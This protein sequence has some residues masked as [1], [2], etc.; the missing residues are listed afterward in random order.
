MPVTLIRHGH[1][2][3]NGPPKVF[4]GRLDAAL[5]IRGVEE[6][7]ARGRDLPRPD[8]I[9]SSP[10]LRCRQTLF[11]LLPDTPPEAVRYDERLWEIDVGAWQGRLETEVEATDGERLARWRSR[12]DEQPPGGGESLQAMA[13]RVRAVVDDLLEEAAAGAHVLAVTHGGVIRQ[14]R[15]RV[16]NR[17]LREFHTFDVSNLTTYQLGRQI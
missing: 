3:C 12:P 16:E 11:A 6:A 5:S 7:R 10:A 13:G 8:T 4:Q 9:V 15:L 1:T 14:V 2:D 17:P